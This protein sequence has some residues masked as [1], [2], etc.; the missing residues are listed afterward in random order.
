[1]F[2]INWFSITVYF[3]LVTVFIPILLFYHFVCIFSFFSSQQGS[4]M[5][6]NTLETCSNQIARW[7]PSLSLER[8]TS[9]PEFHWLRGT[10]SRDPQPKLFKPRF[11]HTPAP[12]L[13]FSRSLVCALLPMDSH[14]AKGSFQNLSYIWVVSGTIWVVCY[15]VRC[16]V[17]DSSC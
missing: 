5:G 8:E 13:V 10:C 12:A 7:S 15:W 3:C 17:I 6:H 4:F 1:M 14:S 9:S 2:T 16:P 11:W